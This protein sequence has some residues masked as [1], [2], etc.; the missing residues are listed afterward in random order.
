MVS[1]EKKLLFSSPKL[2]HECETL[3]WWQLLASPMRVGVCHQDHWSGKHVIL[4]P[5]RGVGPREALTSHNYQRK[6]T[7]QKNGRM[8][9]NSSSWEA[10]LVWQWWGNKQ[11]SK[12]L[13]AP[14]PCQ[15]FGK[16]MAFLCASV[17][18]SV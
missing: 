15:H 7:C 11:R 8:F 18:F 12:C 5:G 16:G 13:G 14:P 17:S 3:S 10:G 4:D 1:L 6:E 9:I 2:G